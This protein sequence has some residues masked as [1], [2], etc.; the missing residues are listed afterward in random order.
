MRIADLGLHLAD[1]CLRF[2]NSL[3]NVVEYEKATMSAMGQ[4]DYPADV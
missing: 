3:R 1:F 2:E 4:D